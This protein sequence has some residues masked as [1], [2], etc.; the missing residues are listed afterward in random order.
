MLYYL[1]VYFNEL[2]EMQFY[3]ST[4]MRKVRDSFKKKPRMFHVKS[5]ICNHSSLILKE[6]LYLSRVTCRYLCSETKQCAAVEY[7]HG[8]LMTDDHCYLLSKPL[9]CQEPALDQTEIHQRQ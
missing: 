5:G 1:I 9:V 3:I 8:D 7:H 4:V 2:N 6:R